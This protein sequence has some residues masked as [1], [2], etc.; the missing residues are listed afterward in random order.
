M[1]YTATNSPMKIQSKNAIDDYGAWA[2]GPAN[3]LTLKNSFPNLF[4][5]Q[6]AKTPDQTA[7]VIVFNGS[8]PPLYQ[9]PIKSVSTLLSI[10]PDNNQNGITAGTYSFGFGPTMDLLLVKTSGTKSGYVEVFVL[11]GAPCFFNSTQYDSYRT[12]VDT[13]PRTPFPTDHIPDQGFVTNILVADAPNYVFR[14]GDFK[15]N[16]NN[17]LYCIKTFGTGSGDVEVTILGGWSLASASTNGSYYNTPLLTGTSRAIEVPTSASEGDTSNAND[18]HWIASTLGST[19][20]ALLYGVKVRNLQPTNTGRAVELYSVK[21]DNAWSGNMP[22]PAPLTFI[23]FLPLQN[24]YDG[25]YAHPNFHWVMSRDFG[26]YGINTH[27]EDNPDLNNV[28]VWQFKP[29]QQ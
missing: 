28:D 4:C 8:P 6:T 15:S 3:F 26:F 16:G 25:D 27:N 13:A 7:Q 18:Y 19:S 11:Y 17:D 23:D 14:V 22:P 24:F 2:I 5:F 29:Q 10:Q 21:L 12:C 1:S 9:T 20:G